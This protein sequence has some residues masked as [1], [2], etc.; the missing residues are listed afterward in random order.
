MTSIMLTAKL[1]SGFSR[2][3]EHKQCTAA[4][5]RAEFSAKEE[6]C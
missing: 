3:S 2:M 4:G 6:G 1:K 5:A